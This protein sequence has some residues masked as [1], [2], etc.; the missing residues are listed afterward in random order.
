MHDRAVHHINHT[1]SGIW[2]AG[3][4]AVCLY[5]RG[6]EK[7]KGCGKMSRE[8]G[9]VHCSLLGTSLCCCLSGC[10]LPPGSRSHLSPGILTGGGGGVYITKCREGCVSRQG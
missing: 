1:V 5:Y 2:G 3:C 7:E 8:G 10:P 6:C 4:Q 9:T